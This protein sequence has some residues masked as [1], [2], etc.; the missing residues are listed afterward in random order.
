MNAKFPGDS[1]RDI[2]DDVRQTL[3]SEG[4]AKSVDIPSRWFAL[5]ILLGK[6]AEAL[7]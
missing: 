3:F 1:E 6:M 5:E 2:V 4:I 7:E